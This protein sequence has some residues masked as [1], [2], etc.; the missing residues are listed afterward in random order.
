MSW[1]EAAARITGLNPARLK[2]DKA[3]RTR[4]GDQPL[5]VEESA[6]GVTLRIGDCNG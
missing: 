2:P 4:A 3:I 5:R 1:Q 6:G